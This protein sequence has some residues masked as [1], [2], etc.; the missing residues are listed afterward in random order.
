MIRHIVAFRFTVPSS[1]PRFARMARALHG[2]VHEI[3]EI[4]ALA[5]GPN[6][7][8]SAEEWTHVLIVTMQDMDA[9]QRY[10]EH[11]AHV[12]VVQDHIAPIRAARVA[13]DLEVGVE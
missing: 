6:L 11:P 9:V 13:L 4:R 3:P 7:G 10:L 12:R 5:F 8:P 2:L 1:D